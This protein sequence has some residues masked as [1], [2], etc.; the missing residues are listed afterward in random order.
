VVFTDAAIDAVY[1]ATEGIPRL[2]NQTCDHA[3]VLACAGGAKPIDVA[4]IE[5]AWSDLQ[6][7]PTPW[8]RAQGYA[9]PANMDNVIEFGTPDEADAKPIAPTADT[10]AITPPKS[11]STV[12]HG[13][14]TGDSIELVASAPRD[15]ERPAEEA[16]DVIETQ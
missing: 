7:L 6:Q 1:R 13:D 8:S 2:V 12:P 9:G 15:L 3:L 4:G 10:A 5:E 11:P 14:A 16:L